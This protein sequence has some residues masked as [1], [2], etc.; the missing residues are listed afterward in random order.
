MLRDWLATELAEA[1]AEMLK[2]GTPGPRGGH[3]EDVPLAG[4]THRCRAFRRRDRV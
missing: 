4:A 3:L 2:A 1:G